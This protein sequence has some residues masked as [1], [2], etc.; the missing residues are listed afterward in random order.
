M[1]KV[2]ISMPDELLSRVDAAAKAH[3]GSRSA[4]IRE[5][6]EDGLDEQARKW[7][8]AMDKLEL[9]KHARPRPISAVDAIRQDR[10]ERTAKLADW[11]NRQ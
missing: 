1:A 2:M 9:G 5:F 11:R 7:R 3:G 8:E 4:T 6:V 10:E